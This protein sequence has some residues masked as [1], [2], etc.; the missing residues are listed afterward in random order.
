MRQGW[1]PS[2]QLRLATGQQLVVELDRQ[3]SILLD[4]CSEAPWPTQ[5]TTLE[6]CGSL[7]AQFQ[8]TQELG[9]PYRQ[10]PEQ[11]W[12]LRARLVVWGAAVAEM[13]DTLARLLQGLTSDEQEPD[14]AALAPEP[15][16][17]GSLP[18]VVPPDGLSFRRL[19]KGDRE[20]ILLGGPRY[21]DFNVLLVAAPFMVIPPAI[22]FVIAPLSNRF[23]YDLLTYLGTGW[24][25]VLLLFILAALR[26]QVN[27]RLLR[28]DRDGLSWGEG[29]IPWGGGGRVEA[30]NV[31]KV[32]AKHEAV[33]LQLSRGGEPPVMKGLSGEQTDFV[34]QVVASA[35][36]V[37]PWSA[38]PQDTRNKDKAERKR[39]V[40]VGLLASLPVLLGTN[41]LCLPTCPYAFRPGV[42]RHLLSMANRCPV[43]TERLG[44]VTWATGFSNYHADPEDLRLSLKV[45]GSGGGGEITARFGER[46]DG[47]VYYT[48]LYIQML[49]PG[50]KRQ[51]IK[52]YPCVRNAERN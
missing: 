48:R 42:T 12:V 46:D 29:P 27:R 51:T 11:R 32:K 1:Q 5:G 40:A 13:G 23:R 44:E 30:S 4:G 43:V 35:L 36:G 16:A 18:E 2:F 6:L 45:R 39:M 34:R 41:T 37:E 10:S 52:L 19:T 38:R 17:D 47:S 25:L 20:Q 28:V 22:F 50:G 26:T 7:E 24:F 49:G 14:A 15:P 31:R 33:V 3:R 8:Q 9:E 21:D